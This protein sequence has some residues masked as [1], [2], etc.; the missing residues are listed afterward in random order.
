MAKLETLLSRPVKEERAGFSVTMI[1][2]TKLYPSRQNN[3]SLE[4]IRELANMILL[5][6]EIKQNLVA[7]KKAPDEYELIAGHRRRLAVKYLVEEKGL[8]RFAMVPVHLEKT[9]DVRSELNLILINAGARERN[10]YE[11]MNEVARLTELLQALQTGAEEDKNLFREVSGQDPAVVGGR[12]LRKIIAEKLGLGETKIANLKHIHSKLVPE[13]MKH[14]QDGTMGISAANEAASLPAKEQIELAE[15]KKISM[16]DVRNRKEKTVS[17]SDTETKEEEQIKGQMSIETDFQECLPEQENSHEM[18]PE[19]RRKYC[20]A[21]ARKLVTEFRGWFLKNF[22]GRVTDMCSSEV[23]LK[24][25]FTGTWY[26]SDPV[27]EGAAHINLFSDYIQIWS[28]DGECLGNAEWF[29]LCAAIQAMWNVVSLENAAKAQQNEQECCE[30]SKEDNPTIPEEPEETP[31][32]ELE[33]LQPVEYDR[34][35]LVR[36]IGDAEETLEQMRDYWIQNQPRTYTK[37]AMQLQAYKNL[38]ADRD[39][40]DQKLKLEPEME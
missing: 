6:G 9:D 19:I 4:N 22:H 32:A 33:V 26:F 2:Y 12:E 28:R 7:R 25:R 11:K 39:K 1:H 18:E 15:Q 10:D 35:A 3:Y 16:E 23:E 13:L 29:Y 34:Q 17:D 21:F 37:Y 14:F 40:A 38:L 20:E 30:N 27:T 8:E 31:D 5:S 36:M 24:K